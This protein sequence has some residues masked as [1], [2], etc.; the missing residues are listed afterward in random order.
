MGGPGSGQWYRWSKKDTTEGL[1]SLDIRRL[2]RQGL[3][4]PGTRFTS[5]WRRGGSDTGSSVSGLV[6]PDQVVLLYRRRDHGGEWEEVEEPIRLDWTACHLGGR[7]PWFRC[8]GVKRGVPCGRRVALLYGAGKYFL[9]RHCYELTY[10]SCSEGPRDRTLRKAQK[11]RE[12]LGGSGNMMHAFPAK[13][14]GMHWQTYWRLE[15]QGREADLA[16]W[17][18]LL[19][20]LEK[21][22]ARTGRGGSSVERLRCLKVGRVRHRHGDDSTGELLSC[23][24]LRFTFSAC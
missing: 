2:H 4:Q 6:L 19:V 23:G 22:E 24:E 10:A 8:P 20:D 21:L 16:S 14:K 15:E 7:R 3:L 11:L 5:S 9:C 13:P 17:Q 1:R 18:A 12:R